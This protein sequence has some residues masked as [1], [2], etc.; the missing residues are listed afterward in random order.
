MASHYSKRHYEQVARLFKDC[1]RVR[2][3]VERPDLSNGIHGVFIDGKRVY[4]V[5]AETACTAEQVA[6]R[7][8]AALVDEFT[9]MFERDNPRFDRERFLRAAGREC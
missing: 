3:T 4:Q 6:R 5:D 7:T 9:T 2:V 8:L 1:G